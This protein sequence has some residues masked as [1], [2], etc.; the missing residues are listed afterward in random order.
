MGKL[1]KTQNQPSQVTPPDI[2]QMTILL[3]RSGSMDT[4][5]ST[6][7][8]GLIK[9][10]QDLPCE[11]L[12]VQTFNDY[13]E[14]I[15]DFDQPDEDTSSLRPVGNTNLYGAILAA[16]E[17]SRQAA[18]FTP[19]FKA[20]HAFVIITDGESNAHSPDEF[21]RCK[22]EIKKMDI[23]ATFFLLDSSPYQTAGEE[24]GWASTQF[25][26]TPKSIT[27]AIKKVQQTL[28]QIS[29]NV[30]NKL[31]PTTNLALPPAK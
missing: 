21:E 24:L 19:E 23:D 10:R 29:D 5:W 14:M 28:S 30:A 11:L 25:A 12:S 31:P 20:H 16:I 7:V 9:L 17:H 13:W 18:S 26:N 1:T 6:A 15:K 8:G 4:V 2:V 3:D 27:D 22:K